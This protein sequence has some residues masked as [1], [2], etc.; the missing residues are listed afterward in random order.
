MTASQDEEEKSHGRRHDY[1]NHTTCRRSWYIN[2]WGHF[3]CRS[4]TCYSKHIT[5][6]HCSRFLMLFVSLRTT[7]IILRGHF[8]S[9]LESY[10][11]IRWW[12]YSTIASASVITGTITI[13]KQLGGAI[14]WCPLSWQV[15]GTLLPTSL[16]TTR[17]VQAPDRK[18]VQILGSMRIC[19]LVML[20]CQGRA[21]FPQTARWAPHFSE[22]HRLNTQFAYQGRHQEPRLDS[23]DW[24]QGLMARR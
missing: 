3:F 13:R 10:T 22:G 20:C 12:S 14:S 2:L 17:V 6:Q 8:V 19:S 23:L 5:S 4:R 7:S 16:S 15:W 24:A 1:R 18:G 21:Q 9:S 11:P